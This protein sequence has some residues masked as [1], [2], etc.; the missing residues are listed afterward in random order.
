M[1]VGGST[2]RVIGSAQKGTVARNGNARYGLLLL[3]DDLVRAVILRQVPDPHAAA[4]IAADDL[5]LIR[6][7]DDV[8]DGRPVVV[9]ALDGPAPRLPDL[10]GAVLGRRHHPL[11]LA[12]EGHASHVASVAV[13]GEHSVGVRRLDVV[14]LHGVVACGGEVAL[15]GGDAEPVDL[16]FGM[17]DRAGAD[18]R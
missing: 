4:P 2:H 15:V 5:A 11:A 17:L 14:E 6:V 9:V 12:V 1:D 10:D 18:T 13:E 3:R 8:V 7:D 16:R